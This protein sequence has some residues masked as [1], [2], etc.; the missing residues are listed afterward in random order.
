MGLTMTVAQNSFGAS[1][2]IELIPNGA[3]VAVTGENR[4]LYI[5]HY[6]NYMLNVRIAE[7][8]RNFASGLRSVIEKDQLR[9]FSPDEVDKLI[10]GGKSD[11]DVDN[12]MQNTK[13][14]RWNFKEPTDRIYI[15]HFWSCVKQMTLEEKEKLLMFV[16]GLERSPL[17]GFKHLG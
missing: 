7:Q 9:Y 17:L 1:Q 10:S 12:L 6:A 16:T 5:M 11:I 13:Y 14:G 3:N 4:L 15:E 2:E 8:T